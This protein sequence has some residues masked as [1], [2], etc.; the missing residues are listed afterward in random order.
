MSVL[1]KRS[2]GTLRRVDRKI[3]EIRPAQPLQLGIEIGEV[4]P[5]KQWV[6]A[7]VNTWHNVIG[8]ECNLFRLGEKII[9]TAI[10]YETAH[11]AYWNLLPRYEFGRVQ[12]IEREFV[13][14]FLIE[15]L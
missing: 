5:L 3:R 1:L 7:E 13:G 9:D 14:E 15:E 2:E 6:I 8:A 11:F 4:P 12:H 10:E